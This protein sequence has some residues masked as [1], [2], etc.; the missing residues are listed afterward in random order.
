MTRKLLLF[1]AILLATT[2]A[3][4]TPKYLVPPPDVVA[5]FDAAPLPEALLSPSKKV[6]SL[7][8]RKA[9]PTIAALSRP[10]LRIAG[11]RVNPRTNGRIA[12]RSSTRSSCRKSAA[13]RRR[14]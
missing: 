13:A 8:Y 7:S 12:R 9:Q 3:A 4:D 10:M 2:L 6:M 11:E 14:T 1:L 5:A